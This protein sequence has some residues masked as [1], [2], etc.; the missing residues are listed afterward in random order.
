MILEAVGLRKSFGGVVAL[1][2]VSVSVEAGKV[3]CLLGDNG[4]GK[5]TLIRILSGVLPP[6]AGEIRFDGR[7]VRFETP[8]AAL[9]AGIAT[10]YQDLALVPLMSA[11]RNFFLG[12]EP[13]NGRGLLRRIDVARARS[14][15][16]QAV[17]RFG[18]ALDD[19]DRSV[20]T[21]SGGERQSLAIA[22]ALHAGARV[23]ILDEP[24]AALG[25]KQAKRVLEAIRSAREQGSA[26]VLITHNPA[27]AL[28][29]GDAFVILR[30][31]RVFARYGRDE[32]TFERLAA[33][34]SGVAS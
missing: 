7:V 29:A 30:Q 23:L 19:P 33:A 13:T 22:R 34:M 8:R 17:S 32:A 26:V 5:S 4:A 27:H 31:G 21:M 9:D 12:R 24:T 10:L 18:V 16:T 1:D 20:G 14:E 3:T 15:T 6:D 28:E 2:D 11:W 25:V